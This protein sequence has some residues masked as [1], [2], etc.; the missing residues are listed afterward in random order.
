MGE[1]ALDIAS[2]RTAWRYLSEA[3]LQ[4]PPALI[5]DRLYQHIPTE[6][7]VSFVAAPIDTPGGEIVWKAPEVKGRVIGARDNL[8]MVWDHNG[9]RMA[10]VEADRGAVKTTVDLPDV[11]HIQITEMD[12]YA[13]GDDGRVIR[14]VPRN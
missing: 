13:A 10:I 5:G 9:R 1:W 7:L 6:G 3:P 4:C 11:R 14:L 12:L 2:G 8:L